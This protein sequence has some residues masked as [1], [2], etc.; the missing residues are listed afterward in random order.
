MWSELHDQFHV[1]A[2]AIAHPRGAGQSFYLQFAEKLAGEGKTSKE[3]VLEAVTKYY[4]YESKKGFDKFAV[5]RVFW[6]V[7]SI[8]NAADA[9]AELLSQCRDMVRG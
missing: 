6:A 3:D 1:N 8:V 9:H 5:T 7:Y 4:V 2:K